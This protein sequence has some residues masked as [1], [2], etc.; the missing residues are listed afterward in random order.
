MA[1]RITTDTFLTITGPATNI[2]VCRA[3]QDTNGNVAVW[4]KPNGA[5]QRLFTVGRDGLRMKGTLADADG[6]TYQYRRRGVSCTWAICKGKFTTKQ[7]AAWWPD[8]NTTADP[9]PR[10]TATTLASPATSV[11]RR[12]AAVRRSTAITPAER[13]AARARALAARK[14]RAEVAERR[15]AAAQAAASVPVPPEPAPPAPEP[16]TPEPATTPEPDPVVEFRPGT[17]N[18][19]SLGLSTRAYN[20]L[21]AVDVTTVEQLTSFTPEGLAATDGIGPKSVTEITDQ[22]HANGYSLR[23]A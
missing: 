8:D 10:A 17:E 12:G 7:V 1:R 15:A 18:I 11:Q 21:T 6:N 2:K 9:T 19:E 3:L 13:R 16:P 5:P 22:L 14:T 20:A 23:D 4:W